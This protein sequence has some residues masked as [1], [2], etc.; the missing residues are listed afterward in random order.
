MT[1][2]TK[3]PRRST[4]TRSA[5]RAPER[6]KQETAPARTPQRGNRSRSAA[7]ERAY[8]RRE[9]RI[10]RSST[11]RQKAAVRTGNASRAYFVVLIIGLLATGVAATLYFTTQAIADS[12][13]LETATQEAN[14]LA[15]RAEILQRDVTRKESPAALAEQARELGMVQGGNP[16]RIVV[17]P[18]GKAKV[19]GKPEPASSAS[20]SQDSGGGGGTALDPELA[21]EQAA[22]QQQSEHAPPGTDNE[23]DQRGAEDTRQ[24]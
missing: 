24:E 17:G 18:D 5:P 14:D 12:Y 22:G 1:A 4:R 6:R 11:A 9:Q 15:E 20:A 10:G 23:P 7:A 13:R 19:V 16:A 8:A 3:S 2:P 21:P